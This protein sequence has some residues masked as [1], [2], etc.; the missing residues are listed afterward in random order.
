MNGIFAETCIRRAWAAR[1]TC[2]AL[3]VLAIVVMGS[4]AAC[5]AQ[6]TQGP[7]LQLKVQLPA[8]A[9]GSVAYAVFNS[10][11]GFPSDKRKAVRHGFA[12]ESNSGQSVLI[13]AGPLPPG[14]YAVAVYLDENG[15]RKLDVGLFGIPKEPVGASNNPHAR[16]G[17]PNFDACAFQLGADDV[18]LTINLVSTR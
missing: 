15:N 14:R 12:A 17:P 7:D 16:F 3:S 8:N 5:S 13:D 9:H 1:R 18:T 6:A 4:C 2:A 10:R 11:E